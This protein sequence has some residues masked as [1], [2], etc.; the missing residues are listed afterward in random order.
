[1]GLARWHPGSSTAPARARH[2]FVTA[3]VEG[4]DGGE[5]KQTQVATGSKPAFNQTLEFVVT[6]SAG[7]RSCG[8][9]IVLCVWDKY[10]FK[11]CLVRARPLAAPCRLRALLLGHH[12]ALRCVRDFLHAPLMKQASQR[13][14]QSHTCTHVVIGLALPAGVLSMAVP[15]ACVRSR[16]PCD[17][18]HL[19]PCHQP[20]SESAIVR[21]ARRARP[22][23]RW[24]RSSAAAQ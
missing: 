2:R 4:V 19:K 21:H 24:R 12:A 10:L 16:V 22:A 7:V 18:P 20:M 13:S 23:S 11:E 3:R 9:D 15:D 8:G 1:M 6:P 5:K 14:L 17:P